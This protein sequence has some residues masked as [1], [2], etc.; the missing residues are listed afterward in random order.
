MK[1]DTLGLYGPEDSRYLNLVARRAARK[2]KWPNESRFTK[3]W[4]RKVWE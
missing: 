1:N 4:Q 2:N 3:V